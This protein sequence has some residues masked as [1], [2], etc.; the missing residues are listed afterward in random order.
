MTT[1][2]YSRYQID[3]SQETV[4]KLREEFHEETEDNTDATGE[5]DL[6]LI[7]SSG[8]EAGIFPDSPPSN[9]V[10]DF[11]ESNNL[12]FEVLFSKPIRKPSEL[13]D[14][15]QTKESASDIFGDSSLIPYIE[16][17]IGDDDPREHMLQG[18]LGFGIG[19][20]HNNDPQPDPLTPETIKNLQNDG[21]IDENTGPYPT[22][23][24][25]LDWNNDLQTEFSN[26]EMRGIGDFMTPMPS[27]DEG[28][29]ML[30][31]VGVT[32][33]DDS[34]LPA[35]VIDWIRDRFEQTYDEATESFVVANSD[36]LSMT[37]PSEFDVRQ[38][39]QWI[40]MWWD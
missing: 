26:V 22:G 7:A 23:Q 3:A 34:K 33:L 2:D 11:L 40:R 16:D 25:I 38:D 5:N 14:A 18:R 39:G 28:V 15:L 29:V 32:T 12:D 35:D 30:D 4:E 37:Y 24:S 21:L 6:V 8:E 36:Y 20:D 19:P 31:G 1:T 17:A 27:W 9:P 13:P 10:K